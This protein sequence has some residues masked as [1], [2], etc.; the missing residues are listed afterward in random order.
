MN[1]IF[2][3]N[4]YKMIKTQQ[5]L[6]LQSYLGIKLT[7]KHH[8]FD[9]K[10]FMVSDSGLTES[11]II[12]NNFDQVSSIFEIIGLSNN[13]YKLIY[14]DKILCPALSFAFYN[15]QNNDTISIVESHMTLNVY[16]KHNCSIKQ[17]SSSNIIKN[18]QQTQLLEQSIKEKDLHNR[19]ISNS[20]YNNQ[21]YQ[22][23]LNPHIA[24]ESARLTDIYRS[25][26]E[27]NTKSF[28][29]LCTKYHALVESENSLDSK[30]TSSSF[31]SSSFT[32]LPT[33]VRF[34]KEKNNPKTTS[35]SET[36]L[37]RKPSYPS[38]DLLP[39]I[40]SVNHI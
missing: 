38:T 27:S 2:Q 8:L 21:R 19:Y 1:R 33:K 30:K 35:S 5:S 40:T 15:I 13:K 18:I 7:G 20:N 26:I 4:I 10:L 6:P 22:D 31:P 32:Q 23:S 39:T 28:R 29:K 25:R 34:E 16:S 3:K 37:P 12:V 14:K 36:V 11:T 9:N 24:N 17:S